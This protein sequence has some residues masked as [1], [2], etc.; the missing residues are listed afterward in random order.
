M[1]L[2]AKSGIIRIND[3]DSM[4]QMTNKTLDAG[5]E[6]GETVK[7]EN[8]QQSVSGSVMK[9]SLKTSNFNKV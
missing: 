1:S 6:F 3:I 8:I 2:D 5:S 9:K 7:F 4:E